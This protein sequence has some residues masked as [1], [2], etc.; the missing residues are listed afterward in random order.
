MNAKRIQALKDR[1]TVSESGCWIW[2]G[3]VT[4]GGYP[5]ASANE[6]GHRLMYRLTRGSIP[7]GKCVCH[8]CDV[9]RCINPDHLWAGTQ[10]DNMRD[11]VAKDRQPQGPLHYAAKLTTDDVS[12]I[13]CAWRRGTSQG[14]L[15]RKYGVSQGHVFRIVHE[16][17][18]RVA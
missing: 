16:L 14:S 17:A 15:S 7:K 12:A 18:R 4:R 5:K 3:P 2:N 11:K 13:R 6:D 9:R 1:C 8:S 10:A